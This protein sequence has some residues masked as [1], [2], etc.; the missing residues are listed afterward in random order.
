MRYQHVAAGRADMLA[1][2]LSALA[3]PA[4]GDAP[5]AG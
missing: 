1:D 4:A 5:A 2:R 3:A